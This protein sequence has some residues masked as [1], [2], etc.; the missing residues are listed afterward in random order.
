MTDSTGAGDLIQKTL[1][2]FG[3]KQRIRWDEAPSSHMT[4]GAKTSQKPGHLALL[5][6]LHLELH[7]L[8]L[9]S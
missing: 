2:A 8:Q 4:P 1:P 3:S 5:M 7:M 6:A 9:Q